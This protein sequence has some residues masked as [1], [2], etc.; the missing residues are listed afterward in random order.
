MHSGDLKIES[1]KVLILVSAYILF[2][3]LPAKT[4]PQQTLENVS[5]EIMPDKNI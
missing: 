3:R 1:T 4:R 2:R 5:Q